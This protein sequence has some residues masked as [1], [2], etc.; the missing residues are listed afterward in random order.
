MFWSGWL[1]GN[2]D[3]VV[4]EVALFVGAIVV[5]S[6]Y[7][8]V[9]DWWYAKRKRRLLRTSVHSSVYTWVY[10]YPPSLQL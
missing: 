8:L 3:V 9:Y 10:T 2:V 7:F 5:V 6:V 1:L 4:I